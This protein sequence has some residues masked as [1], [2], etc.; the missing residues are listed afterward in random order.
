[1][2]T[3]TVLESLEELMRAAHPVRSSDDRDLPHITGKL[4]IYGDRAYL[5]DPKV[6][7][8]GTA[9]EVTRAA[10]KQCGLDVHWT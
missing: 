1:M 5:Q 4:I 6:E 10:L 2:Y 3:K 9:E 7:W 8:S